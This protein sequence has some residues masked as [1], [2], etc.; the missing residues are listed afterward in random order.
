MFLGIKDVRA[1]LSTLN[2]PKVETHSIED[3]GNNVAY[4]IVN[5][6]MY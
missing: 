5:N 3:L 6:A 4:F 2:Q 1:L